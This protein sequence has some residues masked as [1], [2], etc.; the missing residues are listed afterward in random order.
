MLAKSLGNMSVEPQVNMLTTS[1]MS[2]FV[3]SLVNMLVDSLVN[4]LFKSIVN[5]LPW[6]LSPMLNKSLVGKLTWS[7][8]NK[9]DWLSHVFLIFIWQICENLSAKKLPYFLILQNNST[10]GF[11]KLSL[12]MFLFLNRI[13][14]PADALNWLGHSNRLHWLT[15]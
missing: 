11:W 12:G 5:K 4:M 15:Y 2:M 8:V 1:L 6:S 10:K 3:W 9:I 7:L 13:A 14:L